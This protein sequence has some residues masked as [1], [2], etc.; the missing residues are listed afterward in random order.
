M[1]PLLWTASICC[2]A[3]WSL[4][5][6]G[7][8]GLIGI[9]SL[10]LP[11]EA[12]FIAGAFAAESWLTKLSLIGQSA[13]LFIWATGAILLVLATFALSGMLGAAG[14]LLRGRTD[15]ARQA[16][17]PPRGV[18]SHPASRIAPLLLRAVR[19]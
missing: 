18:S 13:L 7:A 4:L 11:A 15:P 17:L 5:A 6:W 14:R 19:R 16:Q 8:S 2:L 10:G 1:R 12:E 9:A 3:L